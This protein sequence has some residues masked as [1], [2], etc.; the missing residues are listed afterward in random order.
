[1][2]KNTK[3]NFIFIIDLEFSSKSKI[4]VNEFISKY[5]SMITLD[6]W[7]RQEKETVLHINFFHFSFCR[8][9]NSKTW[10]MMTQIANLNTWWDKKKKENEV[11]LV[12]LWFCKKK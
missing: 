1:M 7:N 8:K 6:G 12:K 4:F 9:Q 2:S 5:C 11:L 3:S 10:K